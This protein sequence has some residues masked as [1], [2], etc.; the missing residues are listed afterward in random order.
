M[1]TPKPLFSDP[2]NSHKCTNFQWMLYVTGRWPPER[3]SFPPGKTCELDF[4]GCEIVS[5]DFR[6]MII[7]T[8][9]VDGRVDILALSYIRETASRPEAADEMADNGKRRKRSLMESYIFVPFAEETLGP[10]DRRV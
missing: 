2:V 5:A 4:Q 1:F 7:W 10:P 3:S 8:D 6:K 9:N